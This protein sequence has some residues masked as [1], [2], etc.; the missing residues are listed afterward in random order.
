MK[1]KDLWDIVVGNDEKTVP[2]YSKEKKKWE[3]KT[4]KAMFV[5]SVTAEDDFL[6]RI[7]DYKIPKWRLQYL[8][9]ALHKEE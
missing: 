7:T 2:T 3:I 9:N 4:R 1:G 8:G 5:L 6:H